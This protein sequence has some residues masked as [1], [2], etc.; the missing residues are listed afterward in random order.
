MGGPSPPPVP[1][2]DPNVIAQQKA[3]LER[4]Q[5]MRAQEKEMRL[6]DS[7]AALSGMGSRSLMTSRRG[8]R[9]LLEA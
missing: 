6:Q 1:K 2:P 3:A 7:V 8:G 9:S 5:A 4:E